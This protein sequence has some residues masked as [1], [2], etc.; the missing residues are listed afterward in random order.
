MVLFVVTSF[1]ARGHQVA[2][3]TVGALWVCQLA[4]TVDVRGEQQ[5]LVGGGIA[6]FLR[7]EEVTHGAVGERI[8]AVRWPVLAS[9]AAENVEVWHVEGV[10]W[11]ARTAR[12][13]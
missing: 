3:G 13:R 8:A 1:A 4:A 10:A 2:K 7:V 9:L 5:M 11:T 6:Q 12:S